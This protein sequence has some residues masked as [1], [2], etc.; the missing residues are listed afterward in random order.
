MGYEII[1]GVIFVITY[2]LI[3]TDR[4]DKTVGALAG[5]TLMILLGVVNQEQAF[6]AI[7][8]NVIFL[9]AGMMIMANILSKTGLFQWIAVKS[10]RLGKGEPFTILLILSVIT[11][12]ASAFLDNV[13]TV[14]LIAPLT[15]FIASRLQT[16]PVPFLIAQILA[17]NIG[18]TATLIGDPPTFWWEALVASISCRLF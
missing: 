2:A 6:E 17:S 1:A 8:F 14:V 16:S 13:T 18:G 5:G 10:A 9:L 4:I 12:V 15:F 3:A 11:A 7:D